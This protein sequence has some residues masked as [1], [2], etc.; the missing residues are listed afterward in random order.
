[1]STHYDTVQIVETQHSS[2]GPVSIVINH[3]SDL[4]HVE[5]PEAEWRAIVADWAQHYI[6]QVA[7]PDW[8][9]T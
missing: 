4:R 2:D 6:T 9:R 1:M 8:K 5:I 3:V 7:D